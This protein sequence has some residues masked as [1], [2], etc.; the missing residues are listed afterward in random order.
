[1]IPMFKKVWPKGQ[2]RDLPIPSNNTYTP[3]PSAP[4]SYESGL[5]MMHKV[6]INV[7]FVIKTLGPLEKSKVWDTL[8]E[9][10]DSTP[11]PRCAYPL[12]TFSLIYAATEAT[13]VASNCWKSTVS[14]VLTF[15]TEFQEPFPVVS[16][17]WSPLIGTGRSRVSL[18]VKFLVVPS[19]RPG[20][21]A[22]V[23]WQSLGA[24]PGVKRFAEAIGFSVDPSSEISYCPT[25][26]G[27]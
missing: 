19:K 13:Q 5:E 16:L 25:G 2:K 3:S 7:D 23:T 1:M 8:Y 15:N 17:N 20:Q 22:W 18:S 27:I 21:S 12:L 4:P 26:D 24:A 11:G 10:V 6:K 9:W 14:F